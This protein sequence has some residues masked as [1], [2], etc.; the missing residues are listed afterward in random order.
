[1]GINFTIE[2]LAKFKEIVAQFKATAR[3]GEF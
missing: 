2:P 1:M 3:Y